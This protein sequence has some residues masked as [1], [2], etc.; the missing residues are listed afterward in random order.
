MEVKNIGVVGAGKMGKGIALSAAMAGF[1]VMLQDIIEA[2][3]VDAKNYVEAQLSKFVLKN[4]IS[5]D[6]SKTVIERIR[7]TDKYEKFDTLDFVIEVVSE[8]M[9]IKN[10]ILARIDSICKKEAIIVS[11][12]STFSITTLAAAT[13][14]PTQ[15]AGMHFFIEPTK[16]VEITRG[17]YTNDETANT[18]K[19]VARKMGKVCVEV[20]KDSAGFI[21]NRVYTPLFLEAFKAYDEGVASKED[22]DLAMKNSYLPIG[23][24][25]LADIIGLD[26]L[27]SGFDYYQAEFGPQ[28]NP[29]QCFKELIRAGRLGKKVG[30]GWYDY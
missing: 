1:N 18:S 13:K 16:L 21:A 11:G 17:H 19:A 8:S 27:K 25:E 15:F 6:E 23:P 20:K 7:T 14:R 9:D 4:K 12:T 22:I 3:L 26:V 29:P 24:F 30:K 28:W 2:N 10:S 5:K